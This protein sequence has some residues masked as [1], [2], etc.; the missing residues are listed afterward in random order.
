[1]AVDAAALKQLA[2]WEMESLMAHSQ[3]GVDAGATRR[4]ERSGR[5]RQTKEQQARRQQDRVPYRPEA[6]VEA[7]M[8]VVKAEL[9]EK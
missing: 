9:P 6:E 3:W 2:H 7:E 1:M 8:L 4:G 5:D